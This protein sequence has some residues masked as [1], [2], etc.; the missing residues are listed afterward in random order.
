MNPPFCGCD[1]AGAVVPRLLGRETGCSCGVVQAA[2]LV[3]G[4]STW[5]RVTRSRALRVGVEP[6]CAVLEGVARAMPV[7]AEFA[8]GDLVADDVVVGDEDVVAGR[9][10]RLGLAAASAELRVVGGE[11]G[12]LACGRRRGRIRSASVSQCAG[13][14]SSRAPPAGT[15]GAGADAG[16]GGEVPDRWEQ[17]HVQAAL[18]DQHLRG[19]RLDAGD[20]AEQLDHLGVRV[21]DARSVGR[22]SAAPGRARR[23][24]RAAARRGSRGAR[25]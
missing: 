4:C 7:G 1:R 8:V 18:G 2:W 21:E 16:P 23:C 20:R 17:R 19:V 10:D 24:G 25:S 6:A 14:G 9:A 15:G 11:V 3:S 12:V 13:A 22:G 5:S